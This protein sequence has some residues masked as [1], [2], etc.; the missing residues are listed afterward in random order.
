MK[1]REALTFW[2]QL[3]LPQIVGG[4]MIIIYRFW[5]NL[6]AARA[7]RGRPGQGDARVGDRAVSRTSTSTTPTTTAAATA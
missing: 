4:L 3:Y 6:G 5:R 7:A 1:R 2:E